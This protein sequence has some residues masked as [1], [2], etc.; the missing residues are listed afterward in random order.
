M[1][2]WWLVVAGLLAGAA[3]VVRPVSARDAY[4]AGSK[5]ATG[6]TY[7]T[8]DEYAATEA[9]PT[10]DVWSQI[11]WGALTGLS[12]LLYFPAKLAYAGLGGLTGGLAL[13][14]TG[15]DLSTA[16]SIWEPS[17]KGDYFLTPAMIQ[18]EE[19]FSFA[20]APHGLTSPTP[21]DPPGSTPPQDPNRD[22]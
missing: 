19:S 13:G 9:A 16:E 17:L 6:D 14:L 18:G 8:G 5:Y 11:G 3:M 22:S 21:D 15:G 20:G 2:R 10:E 7:A 1:K 4:D 12:N